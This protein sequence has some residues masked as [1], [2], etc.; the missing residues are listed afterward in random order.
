MPVSG[1]AP[2]KVQRN[3]LDEKMRHRYSLL[4]ATPHSHDLVA[5]TLE[6]LRG[7]LDVAPPKFPFSTAGKEVLDQTMSHFFIE[8]IAL[9][10]LGSSSRNWHLGHNVGS[11]PRIALFRLFLKVAYIICIPNVA[12]IFCRTAY[13]VRKARTTHPSAPWEENRSTGHQSACIEMH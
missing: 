7:V 8:I 12:Y 3:N 13:C 10:L 2:E 1:A 5:G 9:H 4:E 11:T 6:L